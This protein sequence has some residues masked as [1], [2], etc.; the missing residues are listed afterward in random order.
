LALCAGNKML[1]KYDPYL[2]EELLAEDYASR[3]LDPA[4]AWELACMI[5]GRRVAIAAPEGA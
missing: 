2:S 1:D 5:A 3:A 4:G